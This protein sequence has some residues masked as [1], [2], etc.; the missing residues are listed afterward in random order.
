MGRPLA[1]ERKFAV[2]DAKPIE[3]ARGAAAQYLKAQGYW[4]EAELVAAGD[5]DDFREV[6]VALALWDIMNPKSS[7]PTTRGGRRIV[8][9]EC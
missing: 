6:A 7:P 1:L 9:E 3:A 5:G 8:G 4:R 2:S